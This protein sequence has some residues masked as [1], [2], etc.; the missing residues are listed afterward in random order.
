[1]SENLDFDTQAAWFRRFSADADSSLH[2]LALRLK[3]AL[4]DL[5]TVH[6]SKGLFSRQAKT[7]GVTVEIG[8]SRYVLE[9]DGSRLKASV[10]MIVRGITLSTK[11]LDPAEW[12]ARLGEETRA[13]TDHAKA[14]SE[15]LRRFMAG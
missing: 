8:Q 6:S 10:A 13:A 9:L 14:L 2:A 15:S 12:F 5:V 11:P 7:T 3:E 1:M 4:P